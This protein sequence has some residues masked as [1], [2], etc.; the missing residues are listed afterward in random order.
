[1][2]ESP[3]DRKIIDTIENTLGAFLAIYQELK[4]K[5]RFDYC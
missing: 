5:G 2:W 3:S 1:L 4:G